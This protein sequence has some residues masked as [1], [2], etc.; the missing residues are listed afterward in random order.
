M[1]T[2]ETTPKAIDSP[3]PTTTQSEGDALSHMTGGLLNMRPTYRLNEK[4]Y[5]KWSQFVKTYLKGKG[6]LNH[7]LGTGPKQG[8]PGFDA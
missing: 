6:K 4:N 2:S 3:S 7:L 1:T 5:L 8:D